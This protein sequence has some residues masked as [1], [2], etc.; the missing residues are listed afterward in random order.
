MN[1]IYNYMEEE[2]MEGLNFM[3]VQTGLHFLTLVTWGVT[4]GL[5]IY[6]L[7]LFVKF[8]RRGIVAFDIYINHNK[9]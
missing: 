4:V 5:T 2:L 7:V 3:A 1:K 8:A 6:C 9:N